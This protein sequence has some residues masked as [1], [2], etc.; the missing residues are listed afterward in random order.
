M[1]FKPSR[2]FCFPLNESAVRLVVPVAA[3]YGPRGIAEIVGR[4]ACWVTASTSSGI[5]KICAARKATQERWA[6]R[7]QQQLPGSKLLPQN[8][9]NDLIPG[10]DPFPRGR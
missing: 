10:A 3:E 5:F 6:P 4:F 2:P 8:F 1:S 9:V 7:R